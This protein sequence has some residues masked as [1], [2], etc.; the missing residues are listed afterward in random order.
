MDQFLPVGRLG[1]V[2]GLEGFL[3]FQ[4]EEKYLDDVAKAGVLFIGHPKSPLPY[5]IAEIK[6]GSVLLVRFDDVDNRE[7]AQ[8]IS[9]QEVFLRE[10]DLTDDNDKDTSSIYLRLAGFTMIDALEGEIGTIKSIE[11]FPQQVIA[12]VDFQGKEVM[13]PLN[14]HFVRGID[15]KNKQ[16][17]T[18]LPEGIF[19]L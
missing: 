6:E 5:F 10:S 12:M 19:S 16:V 15:S 8:L 2:H 14:D 13:I 9:G 17:F 3:R 18:E 4:L 7:R 1:K 11:E